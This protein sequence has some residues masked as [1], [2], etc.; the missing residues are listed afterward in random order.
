M[1][2]SPIRPPA[3]KAALSL[4]RFLPAFSLLCLIL[5]R[6]A[7]HHT[8]YEDSVLG[9]GTGILLAYV[10]GTAIPGAFQPKQPEDN[11]LQILNLSR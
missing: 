11:D 10:V 4:L 3:P 7:L 5:S 9:F 8:R 1:K 6:T 2:L